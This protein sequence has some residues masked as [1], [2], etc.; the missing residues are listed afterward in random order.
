[1]AEGR[2]SVGPKGRRKVATTMRE[3]HAGELRSGSGRKVTDPKQA[4]AI[5]YSEARTM[6]HKHKGKKKM[7][8]GGM[9]K[10]SADGVARKGRT[11]G[12]KYQAGGMVGGAPMRPGAP[13]M[14]GGAA[15]A[16]VGMDTTGMMPA[17]TGGGMMRSGYNAAADGIARTGRTRG[18]YV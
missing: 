8:K 4:A 17:V 5:G 2:A 18:R 11:K 9:V 1:M 16:M 7:M 3:F 14:H 6:K 10:K 13:A 15:P 12:K